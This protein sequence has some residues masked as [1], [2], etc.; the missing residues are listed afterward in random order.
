MWK[1]SDSVYAAQ[2][3][4]TDANATEKLTGLATSAGVDATK[5]AACAVKPETVAKIQQS[6]DLGLSIGVNATPTLYI[7]GRRVLG[8]NEEALPTLKAMIDY[9]AKH[10]KK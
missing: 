10:P 6:I 2:A 3:D 9:E 8:I 4:I 7:E 1:F 5:V